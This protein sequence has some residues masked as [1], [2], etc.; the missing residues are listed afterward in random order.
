[1]KIREITIHFY[2]KKLKIGLRGDVFMAKKMTKGD[3]CSMSVCC[4][5]PWGGIVL[6]AFVVLN[7][8]YGWATWATFVGLI[9]VIHGLLK[10]NK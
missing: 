4:G 5:G 8:V 10:L 3:S 1:M 2:T 6:G 7:D 9:L